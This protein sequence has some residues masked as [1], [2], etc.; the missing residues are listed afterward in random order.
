MTEG[1]K[2]D[3]EEFSALARRLRGADLSADSAVRETLKTRLLARGA[4]PARRI[5][6]Y[7][8][9]LPAAAAA[10]ALF[11]VLAPHKTAESPAYAASYGLQ[12]DGYAQCGRQGLGDHLAGSRF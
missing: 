8:W 7:A 10:A 4:R 5:P 11:L 9:L 2:E 3:L 12:D 1:K 6:F